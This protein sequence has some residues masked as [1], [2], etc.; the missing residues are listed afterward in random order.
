M[1]YKIVKEE[2]K[3]FSFVYTWKCQEKQLKFCYKQ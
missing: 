3:P 2:E 1:N